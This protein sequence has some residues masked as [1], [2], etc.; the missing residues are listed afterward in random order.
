[1]SWKNDTRAD[2]GVLRYDPL[3]AVFGL[4]YSAMLDA[5][6]WLDKEGDD[7]G[8]GDHGDAQEA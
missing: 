4:D 1:M 6:G 3:H 8:G 7:T 5:L 2:G